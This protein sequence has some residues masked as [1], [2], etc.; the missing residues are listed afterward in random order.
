MLETA[1]LNFF[2][3]LSE[4]MRGRKLSGAKFQELASHPGPGTKCLSPNLLIT[5]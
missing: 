3:P 5:F 1:V 2:F 4:K